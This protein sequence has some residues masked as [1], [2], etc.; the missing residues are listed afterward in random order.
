MTE[1]ELDAI[2]DISLQDIAQSVAKS[3]PEIKPYL[4]AKEV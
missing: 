4:N 1:E 3:S 2:A